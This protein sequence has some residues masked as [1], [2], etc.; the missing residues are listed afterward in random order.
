MN[1]AY[2]I[3]FIFLSSILIIGLTNLSKNINKEIYSR[4]SDSAQSPAVDSLDV[5]LVDHHVHTFS[6]RDRKYLVNRIDGLDSLP[7]LGF[8]QYIEV[9][10][11]ENVKK[12]AILSTAYFFSQKA[13]TSK[14]DF[15]AVKSDNNWIAKSISKHPDKFVGFFSINPLSDS[16]FVEIERNAS[17]EEF[18]GLKLQLA[19]SKVD[20]RNESHVRRLAEVFKKA[21]SLGLGIVVHL[22]TQD[23]SYGKKDAQIFIDEV[24]SQAP[25]IP[26]Q[27][28]HLAGWGGY[29]KQTDEA[30]SVFAE[31]ISNNNLRDNI[32][33]DLSA[34]IRPARNS[35]TDSAKTDKNQSPDWYPQNRYVQVTEQLR[36]IGL[37]RILFGTDWPEWSPGKYKSDIIKKLKLTKKE[38]KF[39]FSNRA[40]WFD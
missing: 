25:D 39:I 36:K 2:S 27:I 33:F 32:Y 12:A 29:D 31:R 9:M 19:N 10:K 5:Q 14:Q 26:V 35:N 20:F 34:V 11:E 23:K 17:K 16:T 40:P 13:S 7:P 28:A 30:L 18:R 38:Q 37:D 6:S 24:L 3:T 22:R 21:N 4:Y 1:R 8:E 15:K